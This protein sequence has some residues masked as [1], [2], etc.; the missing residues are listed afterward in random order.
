QQLLLRPTDI[1]SPISATAANTE[2]SSQ[3]KAEATLASGVVVGA[4]WCPP[5]VGAEVWVVQSDEWVMFGGLDQMEVEFPK[6]SKG[7]ET[8][9]P[10]F[11]VPGK[12]R[13]VELAKRAL[14]G[15]SQVA[16]TLKELAMVSLMN[17]SW[18]FWRVL[19]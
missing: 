3:A 2:G 4:E 9:G 13:L 1:A 17:S 14:G 10:S 15:E 7:K 6:K 19:G 8:L 5:V 16:L 18:S 12:K 11:L